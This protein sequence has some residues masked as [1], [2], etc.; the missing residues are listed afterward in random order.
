MFE[1]TPTI[2]AGTRAVVEFM[3]GQKVSRHGTWKPPTETSLLGV[4]KQLSSNLSGLPAQLNR[5]LDKMKNKG[6]GV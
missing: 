4:W 6:E 3:A 2:C 1:D 5:H